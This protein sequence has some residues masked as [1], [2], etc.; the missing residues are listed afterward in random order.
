MQSAAEQSSASICRDGRFGAPAILSAI[1][2]AIIARYMG[3]YIDSPEVANRRTSAMV[4]LKLSF[5]IPRQGSI[6]R[7]SAHRPQ[8]VLE[9]AAYSFGANID[10]LRTPG[11][12]GALIARRPASFDPSTECKKKGTSNEDLRGIL[13]IG[14][15][16]FDGD[17]SNG[18]ARQADHRS[19]AWC[20]RRLIE[21]VWRHHDP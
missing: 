11:L 1:V 9:E 20:V 13:G 15:P 21:L 8:S 12:A 18:T 4:A 14:R 16:L 6:T 17:C 5:M 3:N 7:K 10:K 19:R 2:D